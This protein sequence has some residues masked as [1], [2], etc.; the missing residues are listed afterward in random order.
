MRHGESLSYCVKSALR[1]R[2]E[3]FA[4]IRLKSRLVRCDERVNAAKLAHFKANLKH[5]LCMRELQDTNPKCE[6]MRR[7]ANFNVKS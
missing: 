5:A 3:I 1:R 7:N 2:T 6:E 4:G